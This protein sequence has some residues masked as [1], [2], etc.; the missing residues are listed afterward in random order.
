MMK[1]AHKVTTSTAKQASYTCGWHTYA[2]TIIKQINF[3]YLYNNKIC[4]V[5][6]IC[7]KF[8]NFTIQMVRH[9]AYRASALIKS[10]TMP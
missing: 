1:P 10:G 9:I 5:I 3:N 8:L 6:Q 7:N 2:I 4:G